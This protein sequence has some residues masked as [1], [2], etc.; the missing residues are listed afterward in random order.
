MPL[1]AFG[2]CCSR[3]GNF[4]RLFLSLCVE[5]KSCC[6]FVDKSYYRIHCYQQSPHLCFHENLFTSISTI[7]HLFF[8]HFFFKKD[9][10]VVLAR[11]CIF[12]SESKCDRN[13]MI[14]IINKFNFQPLPD[15]F[16]FFTEILLYI[17]HN[18]YNFCLALALRFGNVLKKVF[19][20]A[21]N[22]TAG[23]F[24]IM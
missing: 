11:G 24:M 14:C 22:F 23:L 18:I 13:K 8:F 10:L 5:E 12:Y 4:L 6:P 16:M 19:K 15:T 9:L 7:D 20:T 17:Y 21:W 3:S 2:L 1:L